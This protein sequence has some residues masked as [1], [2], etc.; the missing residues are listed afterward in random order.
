[1]R[2]SAVP[3][4]SRDTGISVGTVSGTSEQQKMKTSRIVDR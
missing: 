3:E 2:A 4:S 1:M